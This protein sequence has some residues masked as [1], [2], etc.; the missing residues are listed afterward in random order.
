MMTMTLRMTLSGEKGG[1]PR[2][3]YL[4]PSLSWGGVLLVCEQRLHG[5]STAQCWWAPHGG[6]IASLVAHSTNCD[7]IC[8]RRNGS[9]WRHPFC[10]VRPEIS[11]VAAS[12]YGIVCAD[13][14]LKVGRW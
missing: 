4:S 5:T 8:L 3:Y 10:T 13:D 1:E 12:I 2:G 14:H 9:T 7:T 6:P 11:L